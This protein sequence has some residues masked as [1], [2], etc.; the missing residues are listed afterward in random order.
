VIFLGDFSFVKI[1]LKNSRVSG[2]VGG[3]RALFLGGRKG[4][5]SLYMLVIIMQGGR[6]LYMQVIT[7]QGGRM[8]IYPVHLPCMYF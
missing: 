2:N 8:I 6:T 3:F 5:A 4:G 7:M 1:F